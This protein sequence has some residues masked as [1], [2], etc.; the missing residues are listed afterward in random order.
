M[1]RD[2]KFLRRNSGKNAQAEDIENVPV[3]PRDSMVPQT[4]T[5]STRPPLNSIQEATRNLKGG[6][7]QQMGVRVTKI[8]KT[9]TKP[10]ASRYSDITKTPEKPIGLPKGRY[11]WTQKADSSS[12]TVEAGDDTTTCGGQSRVGAV[13]AT[14]RSMRT[15]G[16]ANS[17]YSESH[18]NQTTPSKSV[19]K[20]PTPSFCL[21]GGSRPLASGGARMANYAALYRGIPSSGNSLTVVDTVEVPHF[22]LKENPSFWMEHNVQVR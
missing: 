5:D 13:N 16:R 19:T 2:F 17:G 21:A 22:D 12:S 11:G 14:P 6:A 8:D 15:I 3:D 7:D 18:S 4:S 10:K 1:L 20:P 9:P